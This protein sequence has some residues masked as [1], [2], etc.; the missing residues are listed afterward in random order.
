MEIDASALPQLTTTDRLMCRLAHLGLER[1]GFPL[2]ASPE[3]IWGALGLRVDEA[4]AVAER[5]RLLLGLE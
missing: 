3:E 2:S 5:L 1:L 4:E